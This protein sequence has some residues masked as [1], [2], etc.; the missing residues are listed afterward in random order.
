MADVIQQ[1]KDGK[2]KLTANMVKSLEIIEQLESEVKRLKEALDASVWLLTTL[3]DV[4]AY[5]EHSKINL[6]LIETLL[7]QYENCD[8]FSKKEYGKIHEQILE[9]DLATLPTTDKAI[10]ALKGEVE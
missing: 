4:L 1:H 7:N 10:K 5:N 9:A 8:S 2:M 6:S 3:R